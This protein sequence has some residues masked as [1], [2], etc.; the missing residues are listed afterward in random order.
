M[1]NTKNE[2]EREMLKT[3]KKKK[4]RKRNYELKEKVSQ[5]FIK[6]DEK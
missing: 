1:I 5:I 4:K 2:K 6:Q 3:I